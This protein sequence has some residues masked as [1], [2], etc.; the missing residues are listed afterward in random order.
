M[1]SFNGKTVWITGAGTGIGKALSVAFAN[2]GARIILS[3]RKLVPLETCKSQL[4]NPDSHIIIPLD[5]ADRKGIESL[6]SKHCELIDQVDILVNNA[7]ISQRS[8][9][10][11]TDFDVYRKLIEVNY[12]GTIKLSLLLLKM[13]LKKNNGR[14]VV[15]SSVAGKI[16]VPVRSGYSA[17]K[18]ALHG[19]FEALRAELASTNI[20]INMICPGFINTDISRNA[21]TG[22]GQAQGTMDDAQANGMPAEKFAEIVL[23]SIKKNKAETIIGGFRETKLAIWVSRFFPGLL[24]KMIAKSKVT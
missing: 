14:F 12:L 3:G 21:L 1:T 5:L 8:L 6:F 22:S 15:I 10:K 19:F 20:H 18:F 23:S 24:R 2:K 13:F 16:G 9:A 17:S 4:T 7:G 11:D